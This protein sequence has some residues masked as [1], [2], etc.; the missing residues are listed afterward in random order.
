M[1]YYVSKISKNIKSYTYK[2]FWIYVAIKHFFSIFEI[3]NI[4]FDFFKIDKE[5]LIPGKGKIM[6]SEPFF[7]DT[8][9]GRSVVL[10]TEHND[11][12]SVG[13]ILNRFTDIKLS[14]VMSSLKNIKTNVSI[15][16]PVET[17]TIHYM[18]TLGDLIP[19]SV[20]IFD[21]IYW[22]GD[23]EHLKTLLETNIVSKNQIR[24]FLGY[25]GWGTGQLEEELKN[26]YWVISKISGKNIMIKD[27]EIWYNSLK[28]LGG[29]YKTWVNTPTNPELN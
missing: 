27:K 9:F 4:E 13:F 3:M 28:Q 6:I 24:F 5:N 17:D 11:K 14:E 2:V 1:T 12:S 26:N 10:L 29:K 15:G 19:N 25:S 20:H 8:Y 18:H 16:G 7:D 23:F 22:G 21:N